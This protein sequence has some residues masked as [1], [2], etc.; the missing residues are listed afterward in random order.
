MKQKKSYISGQ[1]FLMSIVAQKILL[2]YAELLPKQKRMPF[3]DC[4]N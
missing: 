4:L 2:G 1:I 3:K